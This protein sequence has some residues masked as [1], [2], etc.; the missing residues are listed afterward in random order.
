MMKR[1]RQRWTNAAVDT[2]EA[3]DCSEGHVLMPALPLFC[4]ETFC[5]E[6]D[7]CSPAHTCDG[8]T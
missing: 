1:T 4:P 3:S 8:S 7:G 6:E 2:R 5:S